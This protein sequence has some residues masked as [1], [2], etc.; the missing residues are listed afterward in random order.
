MAKKKRKKS[1]LDRAFARAAKKP[2]RH[3]RKGSGAKRKGEY[4]TLD[5]LKK[6]MGSIQRA[7]ARHP[8]N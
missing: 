1:A 5:R 7:I 3:K 6:N 4:Y 8:D 2:K